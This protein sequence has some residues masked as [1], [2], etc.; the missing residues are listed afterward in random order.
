MSKSGNSR[1]AKPHTSPNHASSLKYIWVLGAMSAVVVFFALVLLSQPSSIVPPGFE[2]EVLGAP[3]LRVLSDEVVD[4]GDVL[5][6]RFVET[7]FVVQ[8]VGDETLHILDTPYIEVVEGCCPSQMTVD[9]RALSPGEI[10][11]IRTRFTMHPGMDGPHDFRVHIRT[12]DPDQPEKELTI[13]S[14]WIS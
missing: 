10:T 6:N 2:P 11:T 1:K 9:D 7:E 3:S 5:V 14:N 13:L 4:H 8:N 12:T